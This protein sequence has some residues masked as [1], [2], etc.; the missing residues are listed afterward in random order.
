MSFTPE[1]TPERALCSKD[2][3]RR[4]PVGHCPLLV[5]T[6]VKATHCALSLQDSQHS[7]SLDELA[8]TARSAPVNSTSARNSEHGGVGGTGVGGDGV[9]GTV[10]G[11]GGVGAAG[12]GAGVGAAVGTAVGAN[13]PQVLMFR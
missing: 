7:L 12:V 4:H 2:D 9:G 1:M 8:R 5:G 6:Y 10:G 13:V 11:G 3:L